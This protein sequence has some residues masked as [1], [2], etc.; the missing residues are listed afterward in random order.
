MSSRPQPRLGQQLT[1]Q[2]LRYLGA[3]LAYVVAGLHLFH[4]KHGFQRLVVISSA[5]PG[6]FFSHPRPVAFVLSGLSII[7]GIKLVMFGIAK[8]WVYASGIVLVATYIV[9]Y[10]AW[11]L[12]GHGGLLPGREP[13]YHGLQPHE[14]VLEHLSSDP[15]AATALTVEILLLGVLTALIRR[16]W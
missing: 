4:P 16:E 9:G 6:L 10:F 5:D 7:I 1:A 12:S 8:R 3:G 11:H 2:Q 13:L 14:A 15:W